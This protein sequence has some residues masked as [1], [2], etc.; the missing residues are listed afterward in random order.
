MLVHPEHGITFRQPVFLRDEHCPSGKKKA[1]PMQ[2]PWL[3]VFDT[4][5]A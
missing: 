2:G 1:D 5:A 4:D 3:T